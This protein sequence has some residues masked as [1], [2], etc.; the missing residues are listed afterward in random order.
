MVRCVSEVTYNIVR[1]QICVFFLS[2]G[3]YSSKI[4]SWF[5]VCE[6]SNASSYCQ[7]YWSIAVNLWMTLWKEKRCED[8]HSIHATSTP[9]TSCWLILHSQISSVCR[10][11][12]TTSF[13]HLAGEGTY[14]TYFAPFHLILHLM[15]QS[16][17]WKLFSKHQEERSAAGGMTAMTTG[18]RETDEEASLLQSSELA[19]TTWAK[20]EIEQRERRVVISMILVGGEQNRVRT[21]W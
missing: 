17:Y 2:G 13:I 21:L 9:T 16:L 19:R 5:C 20:E 8:R 3:R 12:F 14:C 18:Q 7:M 4:S 15:A 11:G 10:F 6:S 1:M